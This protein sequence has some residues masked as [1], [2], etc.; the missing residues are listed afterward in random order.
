MAERSREAT[1][2][3]ALIAAEVERFHQRERTVNVAPAIVAL[4]HQAEEMRQSELK[5]AQA[6]LGTLTAEQTAA[7]EMLTRGM[8]NKFLHAPMQ[9]L[10][11]A[12]REN[13]APR[14]EALCET[15]SLP[16]DVAS[17]DSGETPMS[18]E[19]LEDHS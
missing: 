9:A 15:W 10:K 3:E 18:D 11:Q 2:A 7:V 16:L 6:R 17:A 12:A 19:G 4:Q 13:D 5:R 14:I 1:D 8:V